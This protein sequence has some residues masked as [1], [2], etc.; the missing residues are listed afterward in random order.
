MTATPGYPYGNGRQLPSAGG[1]TLIELMVILAV[2]ALLAALLLPSLTGGKAKAQ[3]V[4]CAGNQRQIGM[5][6]QLYAHDNQSSYPYQNGW[7][8]A[9]G[10]CWS[11]A[12]T[13]GR[14]YEYG[15]A[16]HEAARP[17]NAYVKAVEVFW[18]PSDRGDALNPQV[19]SCWLGWGNSYLVAWHDGYRVQH[20]TGDKIPVVPGAP[21]SISAIAV[22]PSTKI[23]QGDWCWW[24][25]RSR[26]D[27]HS[28]WHAGV[29]QRRANML[30]GDSHVDLYTF[31]PEMDGWGAIRPDSNFL[32]W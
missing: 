24:G 5:A 26:S 28:A 18:C 22:K 27:P 21:M 15:G 23:I 1:F 16:V 11:N 25:D 3:Q 12:Y 29:G 9:G 8:A 19:P 6:F 14:A 10:K 20:V 13:A 31:P 2:V 7:A 4:R 32:W 17:L 30:F